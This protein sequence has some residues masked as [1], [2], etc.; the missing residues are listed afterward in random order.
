MRYNRLDGFTHVCFNKEY[1][2]LAYDLWF[3]SLGRQR[4]R[5][6]RPIVVY[7]DVKKMFI[8]IYLHEGGADVKRK[9]YLRIRGIP[10]V[11]KYVIS[12]CTV[13]E[14][15]WN[16]KL[17]DLGLLNNLSERRNGGNDEHED[18]GFCKPN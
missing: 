10:A 2:G 7:A 12:N 5:R 13:I 18:T 11:I 8:P 16:G 4:N 15:H 14:D 1:T 9:R 17:S 3:D 6:N